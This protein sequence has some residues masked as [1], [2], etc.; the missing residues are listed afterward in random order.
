MFSSHMA[1]KTCTH[2]LMEA[3]VA[4]VP[5]NRKRHLLYLKMKPIVEVEERKVPLLRLGSPLLRLLNFKQ[6]N[7]H[8]LSRAKHQ[9]E[10]WL[11]PREKY[12][13]PLQLVVAIQPQPLLLVQEEEES[14]NKR[15]HCSLFPTTMLQVYL[16][17]VDRLQ[18][19]V[20][21]KLDGHRRLLRKQ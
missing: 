8:H 2:V 14:S 12:L 9:L 1:C 17:S 5:N 4:V 21:L 10:V 15:K 18:K 16:I 7:F 3:V 6:V 13:V 19:L 20:A 11:L